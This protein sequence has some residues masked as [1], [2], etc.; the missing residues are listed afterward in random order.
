L[1]QHPL[2]AVL[3]VAQQER[4]RQRVVVHAPARC[5]PRKQGMRWSRRRI[6]YEPNF[7]RG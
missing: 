5:I 3:C 2:T 1:R 6:A 4:L 7:W